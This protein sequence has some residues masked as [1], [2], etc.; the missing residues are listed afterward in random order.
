MAKVLAG[1]T[2]IVTGGS[3]GIGRE[4]VLALARAGC[5]VVIAAKSAID[6]PNLPGTIFSV[7]AEAEQF[8]T[9]A[10]ACQV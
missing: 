8:G 7:A 9:C 5:N 10:L 1:K 3:R 2:A 6:S 4:C